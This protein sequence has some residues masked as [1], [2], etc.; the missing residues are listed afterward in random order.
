M[1]RDRCISSMEDDEDVPFP[2]KQHYEEYIPCDNIVECSQEY[3]TEDYMV[4]EPKDEK[5]NTYAENSLES[6]NAKIALE[7]AKRFMDINIHTVRCMRLVCKS[8]YLLMEDRCVTSY[9]SEH[10]CRVQA[11]IKSRLSTVGLWTLPIWPTCYQFNVVKTNQNI[12]GYTYE[13]INMGIVRIGTVNIIVPQL[14][15]TRRLAYSHGC[16]NNESAAGQDH[17]QEPKSYKCMKSLIC[18]DK[19]IIHDISSNMI[20]LSE[21]LMTVLSSVEHLDVRTLF[22]NDFNAP[23]QENS[24]LSVLE[25]QTLVKHLTGLVHLVVPF[26]PDPNFINPFNAPRILSTVEFTGFF[27]ECELCSEH[28][29]CTGNGRKQR[30]IGGCYSNPDMEDTLVNHGEAFM[31]AKLSF[32]HKRLSF[33]KSI[34]KRGTQRT[35]DLV[36]VV[37]MKKCHSE[38][39]RAVVTWSGLSLLDELVLHMKGVFE[40][41]RMWS[42]QENTDMMREILIEL[43]HIAKEDGYVQDY[44]NGGNPTRINL[45]AFA[46]PNLSKVVTNISLD[47]MTN[48]KWISHVVVELVNILLKYG[49]NPI[50]PVINLP[51][52]FTFGEYQQQSLMPLNES[53]IHLLIRDILSHP[54]WFTLSVWVLDNILSLSVPV[55]ERVQQS[56]RVQMLSVISQASINEL[57][58]NEDVWK[59][60][61]FSRLWNVLALLST[62]GHRKHIENIVSEYSMSSEYIEGVFSQAENTLLNHEAKDAIK[63]CCFEN[64]T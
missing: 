32:I 25:T 57:S 41:S 28:T 23:K 22:V 2:K 1:K 43:L 38:I 33:V 27:S 4:L 14:S 61:F 42:P 8:T 11:D 55:L 6:D 17:H 39:E 59:I 31:K 63:Q 48:R 24:P 62:R 56:E 51:M 13:Q 9:P 45:L 49:A 12:V 18:F 52:E 58:H 10:T 53:F 29:F 47:N 64:N 37:N 3:G 50:I 54:E 19:R 26:Y 34:P 46:L 15:E 30:V 20:D 16:S 40:R 35:S 44:I 5:T 60:A 7:V 36:F 21:S